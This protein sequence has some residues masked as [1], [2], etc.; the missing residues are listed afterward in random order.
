MPRDI[1]LGLLELRAPLL[2]VHEY[3][4]AL[5][6]QA[7]ERPGARQLVVAALR[8]VAIARALRLLLLARLLLLDALLRAQLPRFDVALL[9]VVAWRLVGLRRPHLDPGRALGAVGGRRL[10]EMRDALLVDP[11]VHGLGKGDGNGEREGCAEEEN[12]APHGS[13]SL[14]VRHF[15]EPPA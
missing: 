10:R 3:A 5:G 9:P 8:V 2:L 14:R 6:V 4:L 1:G 7:V 12:A 13:S 15:A 11:F